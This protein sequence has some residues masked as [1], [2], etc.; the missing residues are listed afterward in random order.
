MGYGDFI[1][2]YKSVSIKV[3]VKYISSK[4]DLDSGK[5]IF[6]ISIIF[7]CLRIRS[8]FIS[9]SIRLV[10]IL[11]SNVLSFFFI[12]ISLRFFLLLLS[13]AATTIPYAPS[14]ILSNIS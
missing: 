12:A 13:T 8:N 3:Q 2:Y 6:Y 1:I 7:S 10:Y 11:Y 5:I 14:P 4:V 9:L